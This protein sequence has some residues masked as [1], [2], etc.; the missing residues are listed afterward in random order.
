MIPSPPPIPIR[1]P[2]SFPSQPNRD[3]PPAIRNPKFD[4]DETSLNG[5]DLRKKNR[6]DDVI[7]LQ[8]DEEE[9]DVIP[10]ASDSF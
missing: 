4:A 6:I 7:P 10:L 5:R 2:G 1:N 8:E 9:E 3:M